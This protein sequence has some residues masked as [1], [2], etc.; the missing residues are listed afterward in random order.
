MNY[1][2]IYKYC[3]IADILEQAQNFVEEDY[4]SGKIFSDE[5]TRSGY[6]DTIYFLEV[7]R[8]KVLETIQGR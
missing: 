5:Y 6:T 7:M 1:I 8:E 2:S 3:K 4:N